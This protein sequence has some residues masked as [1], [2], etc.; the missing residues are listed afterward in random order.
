MGR[1]IGSVEAMYPESEME[2]EQETLIDNLEKTRR[3][4]FS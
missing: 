4:C 2:I 1:T 3:A